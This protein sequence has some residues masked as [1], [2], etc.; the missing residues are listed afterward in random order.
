MY[1]LFVFLFSNSLHQQGIL[2]T[3]IHKQTIDQKQFAL[4]SVLYT[5]VNH[6]L[7]LVAAVPYNIHNITFKV[8]QVHKIL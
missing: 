6:L 2:I 8:R 7:P 4:N 5:L 1:R 3:D